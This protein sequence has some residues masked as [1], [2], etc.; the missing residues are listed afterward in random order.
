[1][2]GGLLGGLWLWHGVQNLFWLRLDSLPPA[3]DQAVHLT[4][5][6]MYYRLF[7]H[8]WSDGLVAA[9]VVS[10]YYPPLVHLAAVPFLA[11]SGVPSR[12]TGLSSSEVAGLSNLLF[13]AVLIFSTYG[14]GRHLW[15]RPT[16]VFAACLVSFYPLLFV[17]SRELLLD[18]PLTALTAL[19]LY[20]L[21]RTNDFRNRPYALAFGLAY[22]LALLTK[23][24]FFVIS[25]GPLGYVLWRSFRRGEA[26]PAGKEI[27]TPTLPV[28]GEGADGLPP[29]TGGGRGVLARKLLLPTRRR[30]EVGKPHPSPPLRQGREAASPLGKGGRRGVLAREDRGR[31]AMNVAWAALLALLVAG[32]WYLSH[33]GDILRELLLSNQT[34]L[35]DGDPAYGTLGYFTYYLLTLVRHQIFLPFTVLF[36]Y[37]TWR[38]FRSP[39]PRD[40]AVVGLWLIGGLIGFTLVLNKDPRF[41]LPLLPAVAVL[42]SA[43]LVGSPRHSPRE[44]ACGVARGESDPLE[45]PLP[46]VPF[47]SRSGRLST[48]WRLGLVAGVAALALIQYEGLSYG[49]PR[50][51]EWVGI[52]SLPLYAQHCHLSRHPSPQ[53]WP[54][55]EMVTAIYARAPLNARVGVLVDCGH[56][57]GYTLRAYAFERAMAARL[58]PP[59]WPEVGPAAQDRPLTWE[60]LLRY[61]VLVLK[62]GS[63]G[64]HPAAIE[65]TRQMIAARDAQFRAAFQPGPTF[66]WPDG[67]TARLYFRRDLAFGGT[68]GV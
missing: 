68:V 16:G 6:L 38:A 35:K 25:L 11:L 47:V 64:A 52:F 49:W 37:G 17:L 21:L 23:W 48:H 32:P 51:P 59:V 57:N 10:D 42:S 22:G 31:Q 24:A 50:F 2:V 3:W 20:L 43:W 7:Q 46:F 67:S 29:L 61:D 53:R 1:M 9:A 58:W 63:P 41:T 12:W 4:Y 36:A 54:L 65:R 8:S 26:D 28:N 66:P 55:T 34:A 44:V 30:P 13:F 39:R 18:F 27:P 45:R 56:L 15:N 19:S 5:S 60:E 40:L 14:L 33:P 62:T